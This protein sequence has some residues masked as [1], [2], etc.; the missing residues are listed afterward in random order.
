MSQNP[1]EKKLTGPVEGYKAFKK[2]KKGIYTDGMGNKERTYWKKG[3]RKTLEGDLQLCSNGYHFFTSLCFAINYLEEENEIYK[4]I[5][6][7][8]II[9]DTFKA[10]TNSIEIREKITK[11]EI[12][13]IIKN[14]YNSGDRNSG[15]YNSGYRNS[16]NYNSGDYNSGDYNSGNYNSGNYN[17]GNRNSGNYNSGNYNSG[18][19]NSGNY[20]SEDYNSEDYNSGNYNSGYRNSGDC[21]SGDGNSGNYNS[22]DYNSGYRN[23]GNYN[24]GDYNS[25]NR[26]SGNRNSGNRNSG[27]YNSGNYNSGYRNSGYRNSG[28]RNSG[29]YNSGDYNSGNGYI[30][31][32]CTKTR[33]FLFDIEVEEIP[34][35]LL[36]LNMSWFKL[37]EKRKEGYLKAW[38]K[39][40]VKILEIFRNIPEFQKE[41]NKN[42]FKEITGISL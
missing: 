40:P 22:G 30:N 19:Y 7:G 26:N 29:N 33:L 28:N 32:F 4:I 24:S 20:N 21:N 16:E 25:G 31:Y 2:D 23:S 42:K 15:N 37:E 14:N 41:E 34:P 13:R 12:K 8:E 10:C 3:D 6:H 27:N 9:Q 38:S 11:E 1:T 17:S 36:N 35:S 5:A 18:N 39:C